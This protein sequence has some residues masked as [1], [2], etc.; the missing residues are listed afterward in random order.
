MAVQGDFSEHLAILKTLNVQTREVRLP[1]DLED[2]DGLIIPGG[3]STT[4]RKL[5]D[6]YELTDPIKRYAQSGR[7]IWGTHFCGA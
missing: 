1:K 6:I 7:P 2:I 3:E 5:F 4:F